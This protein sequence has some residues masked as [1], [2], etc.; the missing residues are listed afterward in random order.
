MT[1][2][3]I[4]GAI[5][6]LTEQLNQLLR[7]VAE[8]KRV[9]NSLYRTVGEEPLYQDVDADQTTGGWP[10]RPDQFYGK[11]FATAAIEFLQMQKRAC[12]TEDIVKGLEMGGF[13]FKALNWQDSGRLRNVAISISKNTKTFHKLPNGYIGLLAWYPD[14]A[15]RSDKEDRQ[16]KNGNT[17]EGR[18]KEAA[19]GE[20]EPDTDP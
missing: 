13:D 18:E 11:P 12:Y 7:E 20:K 19:P 6:V 8:K 9:I 3:K 2:E 5:E 17:A 4:H 16:V 15:K 1:H 14:V 10:V